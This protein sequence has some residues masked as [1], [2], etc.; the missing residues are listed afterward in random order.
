MEVNKQKDEYKS[1]QTAWKVVGW[2][3]ESLVLSTIA[4]GAI[5]K[6]ILGRPFNW[7]GDHIELDFINLVGIAFAVVG[8]LIALYQIA[9][10]QSRQ[11][12]VSKTKM[13]AAVQNFKMNSLERCLQV[14]QN[15]NILQ[16][17]VNLERDFT[18]KVLNG[19]AQLLTECLNDLITIEI[20][21]KNCSFPPIIDCQNCVT[22]LS[23]AREDIYRI[24]QENAF[25]SFN[26]QSFLN[27]LDRTLKLVL[28]HESILKN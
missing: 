13:D 2:F 8:L 6:W 15:I 21:Q 3:L 28:D 10:L 5:W 4:S 19:Y 17:R 11:E 24:I 14:K 12:L 26:R 27:E 25:P 1:H 22:L 18:K 23:V 7:G 16:S 20:Y 9:D